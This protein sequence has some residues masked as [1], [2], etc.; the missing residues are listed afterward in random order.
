MNLD[1][2][3]AGNGFLL[4][5]WRRNALT[6]CCHSATIY[7]DPY[8]S[9]DATIAKLDTCM[10]GGMIVGSF[11][12]DCASTNPTSTAFTQAAKP[13]STP[14]GGFGVSVSSPAAS[15]AASS[16][17]SRSS[18]GVS[19]GAIAGIAIGCVVLVALLP[20]TYFVRRHLKRK[21]DINAAA[22][23][24]G[25]SNSPSELYGVEKVELAPS[26]LNLRHPMSPYA[27][28]KSVPIAGDGYQRRAEADGDPCSP[29]SA[30]PPPGYYAPETRDKDLPPVPV[31]V[32]KPGVYAELDD[33]GATEG[34][35]GSNIGQIS[36]STIS[37]TTYGRTSPSAGHPSPVFVSPNE[38]QAEGRPF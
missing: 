29:G 35:P 13:T 1:E 15:A 9:D 28:A 5:C 20:I 24:A 22:A 23:G 33:H 12:I 26:S 6:R 10:S 34:R 11:S 18:S 4:S 19:P 17:A 36:P 32:Q 7:T 27:Y 21:T 3:C 30:H 14:S 8:C 16:G 37:P 38:G 25:R 2:T 31:T